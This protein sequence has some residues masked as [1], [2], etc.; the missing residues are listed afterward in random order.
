M[1]KVVTF[2]TRLLF[3]PLLIFF[4]GRIWPL[5]GPK[6]PF[7]LGWMAHVEAIFDEIAFLGH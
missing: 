3:T 7:A 1:N 4:L 5:V 6:L 2:S